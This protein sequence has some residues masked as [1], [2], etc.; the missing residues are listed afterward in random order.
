MS[1]QDL[2]ALI[3]GRGLSVVA[4]PEL[5][6]AFREWTAEDEAELERLRADN[7]RL[8]AELDATERLW[9][10]EVARGVQLSR[11]LEDARRDLAAELERRSPPGDWT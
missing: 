4:D 6:A 3:R 5:E 7:R 2:D 11:D 8:A 1:P 10:A 9:S